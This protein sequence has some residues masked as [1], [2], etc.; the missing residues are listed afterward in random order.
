[1]QTQFKLKQSVLAVSLSL[2]A[3]A[4]ISN[5]QANTVVVSG[6]LYKETGGTTFDIWK[7]NVLTAGSFTV[8]VAAY[9]AS[10][11][12]IATAGYATS[13]ING[14]GELTWL[15]PDTYFYKDTGNPLLAT[16]ALVRC[17]DTQNNCAVYQNG[18]NAATS[19]VVITSHLQSETPVD[20]SVHFRRDPWFDV[21]IQAGN[22]LYLV[23]DYLL[24][25][26]EAAAGI[27]G[28]DSFSAPSGFVT[29]IL[30][31]A[32]YRVT[33][34]S[35]TLNFSV[36]GNTITVSQVPVPGAVWMFLSGMMGVLA[37]GKKKN[38]FAL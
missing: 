2:M 3:L 11:S 9:E 31:H 32:D 18:L 36:N 12:N 19:P 17:D 25:P 13:D 4:P 29:P 7:L 8:D 23:A 27:N 1:M 20:G 22:Y 14:D 26:T 28:G 6:T 38:G 34:S 35:E 30:D 15:D 24:S 16:D 10:Q 37:I 33:F 21:N 5:L